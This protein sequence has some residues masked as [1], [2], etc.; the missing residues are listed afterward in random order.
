MPLVVVPSDSFH[1]DEGDATVMVPT[2]TLQDDA[3]DRLYTFERIIHHDA[4]LSWMDQNIVSMYTC[5]KTKASCLIKTMYKEADQEV[6][7]I[8]HVN[9]TCPPETRAKLLCRARVLWRGRE[10]KKGTLHPRNF[11]AVEL[12]FAGIPLFAR[13]KQM[14]KV[15]LLCVCLRVI[16]ICATLK[17]VCNVVYLDMKPSNVCINAEED[18]EH[19]VRLIDYGS[20]ALL[21]TLDGVA[22]YPPPSAPYGTEVLANEQT[23]AYVLAVLVIVCLHPDRTTEFSLRFKDLNAFEWMNQAKAALEKAGKDA[24]QSLQI[25]ELENALTLCL[26]ERGTIKGLKRA[27]QAYLKKKE[28][29]K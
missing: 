19:L 13:M 16:D 14:S 28:Q 21:D 8:D 22:T 15:G 5:A 24:V 2:F 12:E 17:D 29:D 11:W 27:V 10:K 7:M 20:M 1:V 18:G 23:Q 4:R 9:A 3:G 6:A 26:E 25:P